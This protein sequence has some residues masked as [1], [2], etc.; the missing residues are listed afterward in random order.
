MSLVADK[1]HN[2][3]FLLAEHTH[4]AEHCR[5][6]AHLFTA[7]LVI[8]WRVHISQINCLNSQAALIKQIIR[9]VQ[10]APGS[11]VGWVWSQQ[12]PVPDQDCLHTLGLLTSPAEC[13]K[14]PHPC[15]HEAG[16]PPGRCGNPSKVEENTGRLPRAEEHRNPFFGEGRLSSPLLF[17]GGVSCLFS[18]SWYASL[19]GEQRGLEKQLNLGRINPLPARKAGRSC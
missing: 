6:K 12:S 10:T 14:Q 9:T 5:L 8:V 18:S 3:S 11:S 2:L 16:I 19:Q 17:S 7:S 13:S 4:R 1:G 15:P